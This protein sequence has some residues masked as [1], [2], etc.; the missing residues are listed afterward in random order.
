MK[1]KYKENFNY[2]S[3]SGV[4][5][6][7]HRFIVLLEFYFGMMIIIFTNLWYWN[8]L[9]YYFTGDLFYPM[10]I[11]DNW[12]FEVII[13]ILLPL[14]IYGN[15]FLFG[16][17]VIGVSAL[18]FKTI[19][20]IYPPKQGI[21]EKGSREW[22]GMHFRYWT[23]YFP[24]WIARA[25][26]LPW[27]DLLC[28]R[29]FG[30]K[31]GKSLVTYEGYI[32]PLWVEIGDNTMTSLHICIFSHLIYHEKV[33]IKKVEIGK[34]CIIGPHTIIMPGT[35]IEDEGILGAN[36]FTAIDQHLKGSLIHI[37]TPVESNLP[38]KSIE[39]SRKK[40]E[41]KYLK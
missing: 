5:P 18:I 4:Y 37:G 23:A 8:Y 3:S 31:L 29:F 38:I 12:W 11:I 27:A 32:D 1:E 28:Y 30:A 16:I 17:S 35:K 24:I 21:F 2:L 41:E 19:N 34:N 39:E 13:L 22:R 40:V 9:S 36:S 7:V 6:T 25:L 15:I 26:P 14:N 20:R 33:F 10:E